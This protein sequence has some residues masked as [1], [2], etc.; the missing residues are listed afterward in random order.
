M[1]LLLA[2]LLGAPT[3]PTSAKVATLAEGLLLGRIDRGTVPFRELSNSLVAAS[4]S[5]HI[6]VAGG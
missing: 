6:E 1:A 2:Q 4:Q 3:G 5:L